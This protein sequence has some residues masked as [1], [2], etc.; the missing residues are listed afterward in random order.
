VFFFLYK[1]VTNSSSSFTCFHHHQ[2]QKKYKKK[3]GKLSTNNNP[4]SQLVSLS[5]HLT[6]NILMHSLSLYISHPINHTISIYLDPSSYMNF[7]HE[8]QHEQQLSKISTNNKP[9]HMN[10]QDLILFLQFTN[11]RNK[12][13][14][15]NNKMYH[16]LVVVLQT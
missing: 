1:L 14:K 10:D 5:F 16:L 6:T 11:K 2:T 9:I 3:I 15:P 4:K 12:I 13:H 8:P 7:L